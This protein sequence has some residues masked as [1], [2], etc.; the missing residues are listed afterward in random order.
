[1]LWWQILTELLLSERTLPEHVDLQNQVVDFHRL[2]VCHLHMNPLRSPTK[3][4]HCGTHLDNSHRQ[5]ENLLPYI[6][7]LLLHP[8]YF[9]QDSVTVRIALHSWL[10]LLTLFRASTHFENVLT[11]NTYSKKSSAK[12]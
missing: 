5:T 10:V 7:K 11:K 12:L 4:I 8:R 6:N 2:V 1:M 9:H 3:E